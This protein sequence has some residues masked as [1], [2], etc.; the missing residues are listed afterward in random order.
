MLR[1]PTVG[2]QALRRQPQ[3]EDLNAFEVRMA[4]DLNDFQKMSIVRSVAFI[5]EQDC[6][7][8]EEFDGND[9]SASHLLAYYDGEPIGTLRLRWFANFGKVERVCVMPKFRGSKAV[10][11][12]LAHAFEIAARKGYRTM[13]AQ[14]QA[15]LWP[16]WSHMLHCELRSSRPSFYFSDFEYFEIDI[17]LRL[18][19]DAIRKDVDPYVMIRPEGEWDQPGILDGS[20][21]RTEHKDKAA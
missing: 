12:L 21:K 10:S 5:D 2:I 20:L 8:A 19:P 9:L 18:H 16:L 1:F 13:I 7:F 4:R 6:P 14:I 17:P 15:R 3:D 11:V